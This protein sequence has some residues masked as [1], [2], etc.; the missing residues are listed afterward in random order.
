MEQTVALLTAR[1]DALE[2]VLLTVLA[3]ADDSVRNEMKASLLKIKHDVGDEMRSAGKAERVIVKF[4][5]TISDAA[6][7]VGLGAPPNPL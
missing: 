1:V 5:E 3:N 4:T 2:R 6:E 7:T